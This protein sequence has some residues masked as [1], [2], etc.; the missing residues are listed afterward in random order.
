MTEE[1]IHSVT[2]SKSD[3]KIIR[4]L[5]VNK[6]HGHDISV[7][8]IKLCTKSVPHPPTLIFQNSLAAGIFA[9]QWKRANI[10]PIHM[11]YD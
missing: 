2:F 10:V 6:P 9:T 5:D 8:M 1:R 11:I 4:S 7:R 3:I